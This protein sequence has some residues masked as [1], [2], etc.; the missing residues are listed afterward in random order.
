MESVPPINRVPVAW[1]LIQPPFNVEVPRTH[2]HLSGVGNCPILGILDIV[3]MALTIYH[4]WL[5]DVTHG[6]I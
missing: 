4:S 3:A 5:G 2:H 1:P 6:D